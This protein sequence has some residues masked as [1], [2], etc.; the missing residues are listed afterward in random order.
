VAGE[1]ATPGRLPFNPALLVGDYL[2]ASGGASPDTAD[3]NGIFFVDRQGGRTKTDLTSPVAPG[4][5]ILVTK[6]QWTDTQKIFENVAVVTGFVGGVLG[7]LTA[8]IDFYIKIFV[9]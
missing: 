3:L 6:N 5:L 9:P 4:A 2:L 7:F 8:V 1:V